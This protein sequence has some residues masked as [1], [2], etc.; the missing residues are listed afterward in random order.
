MKKVFKLISFKI[1]ILIQLFEFTSCRIVSSK[2]E[3]ETSIKAIDQFLFST[4]MVSHDWLMEGNKTWKLS[5]VFSSDQ[6]AGQESN[7]MR[8]QIFNDVEE[9]QN[10]CLNVIRDGI[11]FKFSINIVSID[12][13]CSSLQFVDSSNSLHV[14][15]IDNLRRIMMKMDLGNDG[16]RLLKI[17]LEW[18]LKLHQANT[19]LIYELPNFPKDVKQIS[20]LG[21]VFS[22]QH[23]LGSDHRAQTFWEGLT[24]QKNAIK[25]LDSFKNAHKNRMWQKVLLWPQSDENHWKDALQCQA[26]ADDCTLRMPSTCHLCPN[27]SMEVFDSKCRNIGSRYC[28][29]L[30]CGEKDSPACYLG[31]EHIKDEEFKGCTPFSEE[32]YCQEGTVMTCEQ[33]VVMCR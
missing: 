1:V 2:P 15:E 18:S 25:E 30:Q 26:V 31:V 28:I 7:L 24:L 23:V 8:Y 27:G 6:L 19:E 16:I 9:V 3:N 22:G 32:F 21:V 13:S 20:K 4:L 17:T 29:N 5:E 11:L 10:I 33:G 14:G 12:Q